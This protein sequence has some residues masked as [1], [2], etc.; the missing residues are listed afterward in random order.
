METL[1]QDGQLDRV[2][3]ELINFVEVLLWHQKYSIAEEN[4]IDIDGD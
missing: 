2:I 3:N 1:L 4:T